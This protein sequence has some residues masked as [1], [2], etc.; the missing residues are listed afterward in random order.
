[1]V[2]KIG[3]KGQ[4]QKHENERIENKSVHLESCNSEEI[5]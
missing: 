2:Q 3:W 5:K 4:K 1:M